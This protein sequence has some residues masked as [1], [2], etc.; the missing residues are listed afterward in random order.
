M[1]AINAMQMGFV[2][3]EAVKTAR[4]VGHGGSGAGVWDQMKIFGANGEVE[5]LLER[6]YGAR[7]QNG[8]VGHLDDQREGAIGNR[9]RG[10]TAGGSRALLVKKYGSMALYHAQVDIKCRASLG[11]K[12][13]VSA[14]GLVL[15]CCYLGL[16]VHKPD[17]T[18]RQLLKLLAP[19]AKVRRA[20]QTQLARHNFA[21]QP[22]SAKKGKPRDATW[23][24]F[25]TIVVRSP[26]LRMT[27]WMRIN[28]L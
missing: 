26:A 13:F 25:E 4:F 17:G 9:K 21:V 23:Q 18:A 10:S 2:R 22:Q 5:R 24:L 14:D 16:H 19:T 12:L 3:F 7:W 11:R 20:I 1:S 27:Q 15:P 28:T 8:A 6:P